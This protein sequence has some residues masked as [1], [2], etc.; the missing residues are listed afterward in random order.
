MEKPVVN[1][2]KYNKNWETQFEVEKKQIEHI[3]GSKAISIQHIGS[4]LLRG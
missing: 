4:T 1:L 2:V 3:L